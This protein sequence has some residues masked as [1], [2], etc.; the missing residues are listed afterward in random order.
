MFDY[1]PMTYTISFIANTRASGG[2]P[3]LTFQ[4]TVLMRLLA[5]QIAHCLVIVLR[6]GLSNPVNYIDPNIQAFSKLQRLTAIK[7][8]K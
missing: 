8:L 2:F 5:A 1:A 7:V 6:H 4:M 3:L